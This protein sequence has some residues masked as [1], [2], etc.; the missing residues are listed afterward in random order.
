MK[1]WFL[2]AALVVG[3]MLTMLVSANAVVQLPP[4]PPLQPGEKVIQMADPEGFSIRLV[5]PE[6]HPEWLP[7]PCM[8]LAIMKDP[9]RNV[10]FGVA[11]VM[12]PMEGIAELMFETV[13]P[14]DKPERWMFIVS[15]TVHYPA[16][17]I[18]DFYADLEF[19]KTGKPSGRLVQITEKESNALPTLEDAVKLL[20]LSTKGQ[21]I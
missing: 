19:F 6:K 2:T 21:A 10:I 1:K 11:M 18:V 14:L 20:P 16:T 15:V 12:E 8:P 5:V 9:N 3:L 13:I 7:W 4:I 17:G